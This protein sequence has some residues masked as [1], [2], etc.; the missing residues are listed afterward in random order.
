M[1][2][3]TWVVTIFNGLGPQAQLRE[4]RCKRAGIVNKSRPKEIF[5]VDA[6][7]KGGGLPMELHAR[8]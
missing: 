5:L 3:A 6:A 4:E 7:K 8:V 2:P 1:S